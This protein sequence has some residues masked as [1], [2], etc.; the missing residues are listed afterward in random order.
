M[1]RK[2]SR[3][4][5]S[6]FMVEPDVID[7]LKEK[8]YNLSELIRG[9]LRNDLANSIGELEEED[10][11]EIRGEMEEISLAEQTLRE[12]RSNQKKLEE[13]I[14][15]RKNK[16]G[17]LKGK[18]LV[19]NLPDTRAQKRMDSVD[20]KEGSKVEA[21]KKFQEWIGE[22]MKKPNA[23]IILKDTDGKWKR[24]IYDTFWALPQRGMMELRFACGFPFVKEAIVWLQSKV[25][26][27]TKDEA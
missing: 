18:K 11:E 16:I 23:N 13:G 26:G 27:E 22:E 25:E 10:D 9:H 8:G 17:I 15:A 14:E 20:R 24:S 21:F 4:T 12:V 19:A 7:A 2:K 3:F 1:G 6:S 5:P